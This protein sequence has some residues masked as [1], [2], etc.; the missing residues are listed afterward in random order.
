MEILLERI[1]I[2]LDLEK[3]QWHNA[4]PLLV[5]YS[6]MHQVPFDERIAI[7][8]IQ[9]L[10]QLSH[11]QG[12]LTTNLTFQREGRSGPL[13]LFSLSSF[14]NGSI[15]VAQ[16]AYRENKPIQDPPFPFQFSLWRPVAPS[17]E[18]SLVA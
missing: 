15:L 18:I 8:N 3:A 2:R 14:S 6:S 17:L 16:I 1:S 13:R 9:T 7:F 4:F 10:S 5:Q 11:Q 12:E